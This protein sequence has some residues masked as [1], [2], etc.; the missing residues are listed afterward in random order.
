MSESVSHSTDARFAA[1]LS[2]LDRNDVLI[3]HGSV[4]KQAIS[5]LPL[6]I[7]QQEARASL[8]SFQA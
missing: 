4:L 6:L 3:L 5:I 8:K 7:D 2:R 1:A